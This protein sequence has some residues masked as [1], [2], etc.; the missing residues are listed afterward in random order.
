MTR[1]ANQDLSAETHLGQTPKATSG[2]GAILIVDDEQMIRATLERML[3]PPHRVTHA[4]SARAALELIAS[5]QRFD[6][7]LCDLMMP[8][9]NGMELYQ[10]LRQSCPEQAERMLFM[11][12]GAYTAWGEQFL[13][14]IPN[15]QLEKPFA[16]SQVRALVAVELERFGA[17]QAAQ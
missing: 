14:Q 8:G 5:G 3:R 13:A 9:M 11:T 2:V 7:V 16:P 6:L 10:A 17:L 4:E 1:S 12:G 15:S